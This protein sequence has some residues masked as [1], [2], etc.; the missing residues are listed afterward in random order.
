MKEF[1][2]F[3]FK[4]EGNEM[5][6]LRHALMCCALTSKKSLENVS[7][8]IFR[9]DFEK[10][11]SGLQ[12]QAIKL[13]DVLKKSW[14]KIDVSKHQHVQAYG[15]LAVRCVLFLLQKQKHGRD[16]TMWESFEEI[17]EAFGVEL[18]NTASSA[19]AASTEEDS[20]GTLLRNL[21]S[22]SGARPPKTG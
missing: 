7:R 16:E 14:C 19:S 8:I 11:K 17:C 4:V 13:E 1:S 20:H 3:N 21:I 5:P 6:M 9:R 2:Y 22:A 18:A 12:E 15:K 10:L